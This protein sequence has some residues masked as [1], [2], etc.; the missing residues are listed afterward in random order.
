[1]QY[2]P[3]T[4]WD[5]LQE[6]VRIYYTGDMANQAGSGTITLRR[7][8]D[9]RWKYRQVDIAMDDGRIMRAIGIESFQPMPGRRFWLAD[10]WQADR[11]RR[12][13]EFKASMAVRH[14]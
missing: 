6:G 10:D 14:V 3:K 12:I 9:P 2:G 11:N 7:P 13:E 8:I 5:A 1:M 4:A